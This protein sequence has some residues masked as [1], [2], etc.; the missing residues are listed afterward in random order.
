MKLIIALGGWDKHITS[1]LKKTLKMWKLTIKLQQYNNNKVKATTILYHW[2]Y[3]W[4]SIGSLI[5]QCKLMQTNLT[6]E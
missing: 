6:S 4:N 5:E 3:L 1:E 2:G